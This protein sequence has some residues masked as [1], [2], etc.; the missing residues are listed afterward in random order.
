[1]IK[2][3]IVTFV[4]PSKGIL[5]NSEILAENGILAPKKTLSRAFLGEVFIF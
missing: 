2:K 1:M 3:S 5:K 4:W